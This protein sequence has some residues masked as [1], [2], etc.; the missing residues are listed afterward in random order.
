MRNPYAVLGVSKSASGQDIK[1]AFRLQA[2][3]CHPDRNL[4]DPDASAVFGEINAAYEI[5]GN[6]EKRELFDRGLIGAD[7]RRRVKRSV[8]R[9]FTSS[10]SGFG[11]KRRGAAAS[12]P[13]QETDQADKGPEDSGAFS[14]SS[15][16]EIMEHIFGQSFVRTHADDAPGLDDIPENQRAKA[17]NSSDPDIFMDLAIPLEAALRRSPLTVDLPDGGTVAIDLP[18]GIENGRVVRVAGAGRTTDDD[19]T[20][21]LIVSLRFERHPSLKID[22]HHLVCELPVQL[23]EGI[24][25]TKLPVD[26]LDGRILVAI[27]PWSG[28]DRVLRIAEKGLPDHEGK[29]GDLLVQIRLLL[30]DTPVPELEAF[31]QARAD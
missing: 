28:S 7:G 29:R 30:P 16:D 1:T 20:G 11:F 9:E 17:T 24:A 4:E 31:G 15:P 18:T 22:G 12:E 21:D 3:E 26:T 13:Q 23:H 10:M 5:L 27:P 8:F 19:R 25:G 2:K 6:P 14:K